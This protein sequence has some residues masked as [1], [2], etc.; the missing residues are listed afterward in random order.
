MHLDKNNINDK[1]EVWLQ[2]HI[3]RSHYK[4]TLQ[5]HITRSHYKITLCY[6]YGKL[7]HKHNE[8]LN[9]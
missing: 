5:D 1:G 8:N 6:Q 3:T 4:I 9:K 2:Y 7:L